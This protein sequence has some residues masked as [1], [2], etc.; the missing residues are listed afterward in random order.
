MKTTLVA[1]LLTFSSTVF[2]RQYIQCSTMDSNSTD[3]MVVNLQTEQ[4]GTLFISSGMQNDES[5]RLLVNIEFDKIE[6]KHHVYKVVGEAGEGFV[7][8][9]SEAIGKSSNFV[10][11]DLSFNSYYFT[12]S[13]FARIYN[14]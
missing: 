13:C 11:V 6:K 7:K 4:G 8:V 2:A 3:V 1:L 5:E 9:P 12:F 14:D 10:M